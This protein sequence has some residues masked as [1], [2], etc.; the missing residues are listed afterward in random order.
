MIK[1]YRGWHYQ[2]F[3]KHHNQPLIAFQASAFSSIELDYLCADLLQSSSTTWGL[4]IKPLA[5]MAREK[6][7]KRIAPTMQTCADK[8]MV[9]LLVVS[10]KKIHVRPEKNSIMSPFQSS[11]VL[12]TVVIQNFYFQ[13][14]CISPVAVKITYVMVSNELGNISADL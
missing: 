11:F 5:L 4:H 10:S 1:S 8:N 9:S 2:S 3:R 12:I 13:S 6:K 14:F 7:P